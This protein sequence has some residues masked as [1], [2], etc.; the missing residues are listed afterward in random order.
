MHPC[1]ECPY[2]KDS[3]RFRKCAKYK[4]MVEAS[5]RYSQ[6]KRDALVE[7]KMKGTE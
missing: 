6:M 5:T 4:R 7:D 1:R 3:C 2:Q